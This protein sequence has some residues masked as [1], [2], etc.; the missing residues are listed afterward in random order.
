MSLAAVADPFQQPLPLFPLRTVLFPGGLLPLKVFEAR[1][2][3]LVSRCLREQQPFGVIC[4]RQGDEVRAEGRGATKAVKLEDVGV[5][6]TLGEVNADE[7]G[8]LRVQ[9]HG[10][11]RFQLH[12]APWQQ[13]DGLWLGQAQALAADPAVPPPATLHAAVQSLAQA[14]T[15]LKAQGHDPFIEPHQL[16]DAAWV[17]NRWCELLPI[18]LAARQQL[19]QLPDPVLRLQLVADFLKKKGLLGGASS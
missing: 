12:G 9:C 5:L 11:T 10:G 16:G 6:A 13:D 4:L 8:I 7:P 17:A 3:D 2:I 14:I 1:Y 15:S 19:M 18:S